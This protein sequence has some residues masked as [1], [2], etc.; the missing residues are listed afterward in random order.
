ML[1]RFHLIRQTEIFKLQL[2]LKWLALV[3]SWLQY[4]CICQ[5]LCI[6]H[7]TCYTILYWDAVEKLE[8]LGKQCV[9]SN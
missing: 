9:L 1:E 6:E 7:E 3:S 5:V 2:K 8:T 4:E